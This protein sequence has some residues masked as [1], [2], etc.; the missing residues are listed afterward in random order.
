SRTTVSLAR[1]NQ[2]RSRPQGVEPPGSRDALELVLA[3]VLEPEAR[4]DDET[5]HRLTH[6]HLTGGRQVTHPL[7][8]AHRQAAEVIA[9]HFDLAGVHPGPQLEAQILRTGDDLGRAPQCPS[10]GIERGQKAIA[11]CL[12]LLSPVT[13]ERSPDHGVMAIGESGPFPWS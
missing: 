10:G 5:P 7:G 11:G 12:N 2:R 1:A 8:D 9:T 13:G 6:Q 3:L 4:T